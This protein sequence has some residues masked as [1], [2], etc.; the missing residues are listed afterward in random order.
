VVLD[1][2][3]IRDRSRWSLLRKFYRERLNFSDLTT[4]VACDEKMKQRIGRLFND[5]NDVPESYVTMGPRSIMNAKHL[6]LAACGAHKAEIIRTFF[7]R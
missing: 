4:E 7:G 6:I 1:A 5:E 2:I 3:F